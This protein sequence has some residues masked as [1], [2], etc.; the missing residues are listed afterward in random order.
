MRQWIT[1]SVLALCLAAC[2][3]KNTESEAALN[4]EQ[5]MQIVDSVATETKSRV[6]DLE[7]SV[8]D[9]QKD[10]DSLLNKIEE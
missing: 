8:D 9:L 10:V 5:E 6:D 2:G 4:P 1:I 3:P 7:K